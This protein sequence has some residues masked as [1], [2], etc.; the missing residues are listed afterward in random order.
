MNAILVS[1]GHSPNFQFG[2]NPVSMAVAEAVLT[3]IEEEGLQQHSKEVGT[4]LMESLTALQ[5]KHACIG[6]VRGIGLFI[7]V[8]IVKDRE[9]RE[10]DVDLAKVLKFR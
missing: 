8:D 2:G 1:S 4:F 10:P 7:G 5:E 6:D 9:S 3:V